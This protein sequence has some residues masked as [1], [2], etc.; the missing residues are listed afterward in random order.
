MAVETKDYEAVIDFLQPPDPRK[1]RAQIPVRPESTRSTQA[2]SG[3]GASLKEDYEYQKR[4][5]EWR[6]DYQIFIAG[7]VQ[8]EA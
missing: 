1:S 2:A 7:W 8:L 3:L 6:R 5:G 4:T